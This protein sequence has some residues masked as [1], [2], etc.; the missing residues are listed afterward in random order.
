MNDPFTA[1]GQITEGHQ[2]IVS[3][4]GA[5][6]DAGHDRDD[7]SSGMG[8]NT[9]VRNDRYRTSGPKSHKNHGGSDYVCTND[10]NH[11]Y[12]AAS[13]DTCVHT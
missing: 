13:L 6:C 11:Y 7:R 9:F 2:S 3:G 5:V 8:G 4:E 12:D 10:E 1:D